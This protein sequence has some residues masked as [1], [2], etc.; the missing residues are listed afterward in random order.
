VLPSVHVKTLGIRMLSF[1]KLYQHFRL[2]DHPY[3]LQDSLSTLNLLCSC[4]RTPPQVQDSIRVGG[5]PFP[6]GDSH[7][8]RYAEL[9]SAR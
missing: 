5:Q 2:R 3:G 9:C 6:D 7:P 1:S 8:A 4:L